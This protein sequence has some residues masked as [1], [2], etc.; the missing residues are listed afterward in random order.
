MVRRTGIGHARPIGVP[1][2]NVRCSANYAMALS[3]LCH[4]SNFQESRHPMIQQSGVRIA[5]RAGGPA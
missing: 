4:Q 1:T 3:T 5:Q 2:A